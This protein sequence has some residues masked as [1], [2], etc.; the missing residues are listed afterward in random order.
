MPDN[1]RRWARAVRIDRWRMTLDRYDA[2]PVA[3]VGVSSGDDGG[4]LVVCFPENL[5][6]EEVA[7]LLET[8]AAQ[9]RR[10]PP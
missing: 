6:P 1:K 10:L 3:L 7:L 5:T 9:A 4:D 8:A 2:T